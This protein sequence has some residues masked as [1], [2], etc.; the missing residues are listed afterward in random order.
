MSKAY[1]LIASTGE[2]KSTLAKK[3]SDG[4]PCLFFD[5]NGEHTD[6]STNNKEKRSRFFGNPDDFITL[7][8]NKHGGTWCVF[9]EATGFLM[10]A[11]QKKM[12]SFL[13]AKRH[14]VEYGGRNVV[15]LFHTIGSVPP[16]I[17]DMC[18]YIVL[19]KTGDDIATVKKKR[20]KLLEP[21]MRLQ[22]MGKYS[23]IIIKN[24]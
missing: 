5:V 19:F 4:K 12:R 11:I 6:L 10:G 17:L 23:K 7:C 20:S 1:C 3:L 22:R 15:F 18:D 24:T 9:E 16:F 8:S 13:I 14:P 21:F 2:G